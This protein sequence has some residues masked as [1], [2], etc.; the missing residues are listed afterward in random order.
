MTL[1]RNPLKQVLLQLH[2]QALSALLGWKGKHFF[3]QFLKKKIE[4]CG[5]ETPTIFYY[6]KINKILHLRKLHLLKM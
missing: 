1:Q 6:V 5:K 3:A 2:L 4:I